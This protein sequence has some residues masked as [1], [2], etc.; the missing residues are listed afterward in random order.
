MIIQQRMRCDRPALELCI[1]PV[2]KPKLMTGVLVFLLQKEANGVHAVAD[3]ESIPEGQAVQFRND[4]AKPA[5]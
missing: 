4:S 2:L 3:P 5:A 1:W